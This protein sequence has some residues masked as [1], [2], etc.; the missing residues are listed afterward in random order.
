MLAWRMTMESTNREEPWLDPRLKLGPSPIHGQGT[1]A[2]ALIDAG[3]V[4]SVW[5]GRLATAQEAA[6]AKALGKL[7]MQVDDDVYAVEERGEHE[8]YF[9][10]HSCDPNVRMA[11]AL[12]MAARRRIAPGGELT[13][14]YALFEEDEDFTM[15]WEC[16]CGSPICRKRITGRDWR[17]PDLQQRYAG[18]FLPAIAQRIARL[19]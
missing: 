17:L 5:G 15:P 13:V 2:T 3:E 9:M 14:D 10:N 18:H 4:V 7:V 16:I 19:T 11:G 8:T 1:F 6:R 12:T